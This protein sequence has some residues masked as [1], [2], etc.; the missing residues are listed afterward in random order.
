MS[1]RLVPKSVTL[2]DLERRNGPYF[3]LFTEFGSFR[4]SLRV[5]VAED[6]VMFMF[7]ISSP[8]EFLVRYTSGQT[9][10]HA[11]CNTLHPSR[12]TGEVKRL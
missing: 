4:G 9:Y 3:A 6:V 1:F 11:D 8:D 12:G 5:K 7:A 2:V 10:R